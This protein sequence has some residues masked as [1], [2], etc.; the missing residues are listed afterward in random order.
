VISDLSAYCKFILMMHLLLIFL[1]VVQEAI[2]VAKEDHAHHAEFSCAKDGITPLFSPTDPVGADKR[3]VASTGDMFIQSPSLKL[4]QVVGGSAQDD[5]QDV[6]STHAM[7]DMLQR[8][9]VAEID[10]LESQVRQGQ[11]ELGLIEQRLGQVERKLVEEETAKIEHH[12]GLLMQEH[13][14]RGMPGVVQLP[15]LQAAQIAQG[16]QIAPLQTAPLSQL[17]PI[18]QG[19]VP[20]MQGLQEWLQPMMNNVQPQQVQQA[21]MAAPFQGLLPNPAVYAGV[22]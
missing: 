5:T 20:Q 15:P 7:E 21:A 4:Q 18:A 14:P 3:K 22:R 9:Q 6:A 11:A 13:M 16:V 12:L 2:V 1:A 17:P 19:Q 8:E 10:M